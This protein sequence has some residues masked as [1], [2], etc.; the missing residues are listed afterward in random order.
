MVGGLQT[1]AVP[2]MTTAI[3]STNKP[4]GCFSS[5]GSSITSTP[6][7]LS[8]S[9]SSSCSFRAFS[10]SIG[11]EP[12]RSKE[13]ESLNE[14]AMRE[15]SAKLYLKQGFPF[16]V[17]IFSGIVEWG[18]STT[19]A[20]CRH[21]RHQTHHKPVIYLCGEVLSKKLLRKILFLYKWTKID[22][23]DQI[24][25]NRVSLQDFREN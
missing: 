13:E 9:T 7:L 19:V 1:S 4:S 2:L 6:I 15:T 16:V 24:K 23:N 22:L 18:H 12:F 3:S 8:V 20:I 5:Q 21:F 11:L 14:L 10:I 17:A 25:K